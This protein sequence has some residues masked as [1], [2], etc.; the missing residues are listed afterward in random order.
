MQRK[1]PKRTARPSGGDGGSASR[2]IRG[3]AA[4]RSSGRGGGGGGIGGG[5]DDE[6]QG[7]PTPISSMGR[8]N[9]PRRHSDQVRGQRSA[10]ENP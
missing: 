5:D 7:V 10:G 4:S 6:P 9:P 1:N 3:R 2:T 8:P